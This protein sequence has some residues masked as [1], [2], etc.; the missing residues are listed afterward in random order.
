MAYDFLLKF[1]KTLWEH[2]ILTPVFSEIRLL[3]KVLM[4]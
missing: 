3:D 1:L 2:F 4:M